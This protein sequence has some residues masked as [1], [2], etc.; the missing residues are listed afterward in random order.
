M[1]KCPLCDSKILKESKAE[2]DYSNFST[3]KNGDAI[4]IVVRLKSIV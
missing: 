1:N 4:R 2:N 3:S